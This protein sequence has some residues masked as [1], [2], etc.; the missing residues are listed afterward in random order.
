VYSKKLELLTNATVIDEAIRFVPSKSK[1][2]ETIEGS[3]VQIMS[4]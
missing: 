1:D 3:E 2:K 4:G